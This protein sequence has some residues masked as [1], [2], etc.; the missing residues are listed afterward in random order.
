MS[1][2]IFDNFDRIE[3]AVISSVLEFTA[4][5]TLNIDIVYKKRR[6]LSDEAMNFITEHQDLLHE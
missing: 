2:E 4:I 6:G 3:K 5:P 1:K